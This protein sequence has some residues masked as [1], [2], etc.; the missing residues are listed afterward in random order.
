M[1]VAIDV[2]TGMFDRVGINT[3]VKNMLGM[4]FQPCHMSSG[5]SEAAYDRRM[6][7]VGPYFMEGKQERV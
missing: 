4:V 5:H 1:Q 7:E 6:T 2:L 3:K